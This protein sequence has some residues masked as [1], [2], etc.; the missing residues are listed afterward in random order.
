MDDWP[1][2]APPGTRATCQDELGATADHPV[3][4][5][6]V[7]DGAG[8]LPAVAELVA[9]L[10][11]RGAP[12]YEIELLGTDP[13]ADRRLA[14][15]AEI[16]LPLFP[17]QRLGVPS[18]FAVAQALVERRY[19][20]VHL[21]APAP[22][23]VI[24]LLMATLAG[25]PVTATYDEGILRTDTEPPVIELLCAYYGQ[26]QV[27]LSTSCA[28]D[29]SLAKLGIEPSAIARWRPGV[30]LDRFN[31]SRYAP[32]IQPDGAFELLHVGALDRAAEADLLVESFLIAHDS[33]PGTTAR[34]RRLQPAGGAAAS[35]AGQ[36]RNRARLGPRP[37]RSD[38]GRRRP[39]RSDPGRRRPSRSDPGRRRPSRSDPGRCDP[40][41]TATPAGDHL[42][43]AYV[44]ADLLIVAGATSRDP[45]SILEAQASGLPVLA[46]DAGGAV[47][48]IESGRSGCLV[49]ADPEALAG[50][51][52]WLAR[53]ATLRKRLASGGLVAARA[54]T[55]ERSLAQLAGAWSR[56]LDGRTQ[57]GEV[58]RAA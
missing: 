57:A 22:A 44:S 31:P 25:V 20:A 17:D 9:Q 45:Q 10:R 8:A 26:C 27:V 53:R 55:W 30:D 38:P 37:G 40:A 3:R 33:R 13:D 28:A 47:E 5:A 51:L 39:S 16:D 4:I 49:P 36:F 14:A 7:A 58:P 29:A 54:L 46:V 52:R 35:A 24:A 11:G 6:V 41:A 21:C 1:N 2:P 43:H 19:D 32:D 56:A 15:A 48:L 42:A 50:A 12:G 34:V 23:A 18:L